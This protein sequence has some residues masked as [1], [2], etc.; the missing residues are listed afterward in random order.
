ML[1]RLPLLCAGSPSAD[2]LRGVP[3][4]ASAVLESR[5]ESRFSEMSVSGMPNGGASRHG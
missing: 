4:R 2:G 1:T 5:D 3:R